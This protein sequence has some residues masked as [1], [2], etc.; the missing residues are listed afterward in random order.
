MAF[1]LVA[2]KGL[3]PLVSR[4]PWLV[5][6]A[7]RWYFTSERLAA[8][9]YVDVFPRNES[10][11]V[12]LGGVASFQLHLQ[13]MNLTPFELELDRAN[14]HFWCGGVRL[15]GQVLEKRKISPGASESLFLSG[16]IPDGAANQIAALFRGNQASLDGNIEFNC[17]VRSFAKR[18]GSLSGIQTLFVNEHARAARPERSD[19]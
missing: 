9:V 4:V 16:S 5:A 13:L 12:D 8:L 6:V 10:A 17:S 1:D 18:V 7:G 14:F 3:W 2:V 11:R 15:D 19:A